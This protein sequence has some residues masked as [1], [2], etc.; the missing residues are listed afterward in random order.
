M[1]GG[2]DTHW[3][4][5]RQGI[6][7][8]VPRK[9]DKKLLM[10]E[11]Q[12]TDDINMDGQAY[13]AMVRSPYA[14]GIIRSINVENART[15]PGVLAVYVGADLEKAGYGHI[16]CM[17]P[18]AH[19]DGSPMKQPAWPA[20][21]TDRVYFVGDALACVVAETALQAKDAADAVEVDID[22]LPAII[23]M[24]EAV[25]PG[26]PQLYDMIPNNIATEFHYGESDKVA[27]A[28]AQAAHVTKLSLINSRII[29]NPMEPRS[30]I[31]KYD[32]TEDR[33]II[34]ACSQ[35]VM[36]L[37]NLLAK[38]ILKIPPEKIRVLTGNVGGSFGMKIPVFPEYVCLIHAARAL[39]RPVKWTDER[40]GSFVSD[41]HGRDHEYD[42]E[43]AL[44][45]DGNFLALRIKVFGG[46]GGRLAGAGPHP[47]TGNIVRNAISLYKT[48]LIEVTT[49]CVVTNTSP[50]SA[51][52]G[53]G[54]PEANY[55]MERLIESAAREMKI[56][57][58]ELRRRNHIKPEQM[59]H[60]APSGAIYD[61]GEFPAI[62]DEA[63]DRADWGGFAARKLDSAARG[64]LRGIGMSNF[65][66][67]TAPLGNEMGAIRF[68]PDGTVTL[69]SGTLDYGQGHG[70]AFAQLIEGTLGIPFDRIK[71]VQ[72]DSDQLDIG[73]GSG[74]SKSLMSGGSA[75]LE[76][77]EQV[78]DNGKK[79]AAVALEA[80]ATDIEFGQGRFTIAGTDRAIGILDLAAKLRAG[81]RSDH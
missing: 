72:G 21:A 23:K 31:V 79:I 75:L 43:L 77:S 10:G 58:I 27:A 34:Q 17:M 42:A 18:V 63:L 49:Y 69:F 60:T 12:Y 45:K 55:V 76:A 73:G 56:D 40:S 81:I 8:P 48:P 35:G 74:G 53:A 19:R 59:P 44:D 52:R 29:V 1:D 5:Q 24:R 61:G 13:M 50:V 38:D 57:S 47:P 51:Y 54:R 66:E 22:P 16:K 80:A 67:A 25:K 68:E 26:A 32:R 7:M 62:F 33:W 15:M 71:L 3:G 41:T 14:H 70:T 2:D 37:R 39:G 6:G 9:E 36:G 30:A 11:G 4:F 65:L 78:I 28:F 46:L 20:L 64:K